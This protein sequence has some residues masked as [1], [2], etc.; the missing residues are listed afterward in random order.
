MRMPFPPLAFALAVLLLGCQSAPPPIELTDALIYTPS[1]TVAARLRGDFLAADGLAERMERLIELEGQALDLA[2]YEPLKLGALGHAILDLNYASLSGHYVLGRFYDHVGAAET[3]N[4]HGAWEQAVKEAMRVDAS[5][6]ADSPYA[7]ITP[8]EAQFYLRSE[9]LAPVGA[10]YRSSKATPFMLLVLGRPQETAPLRRLH[11]ALDGLHQVAIDRL[12]TDALG[13]EFSP[14]RLTGF[15]ARQGD[16]AAQTALGI[17]LA[18]QQR[19]DDALDWLQAGTR[20]D[21]VIAHNALARIHAAKSFQAETPEE[22]EAALENVLENSLRAISLG[23]SEAMYR[24]AAM[25]LEGVFGEDNAT[26]AIPLLRQAGELD[27]SDALL[28]LAYLHYAGERVPR[29][30]AKARDYFVRSAALKNS[31]ARLGYARYLMQEGTEGEGAGRAVGWLEEVVRET[32]DPEAMLMLGNLHARGV[33]ARQNFRAARRWYRQAAAAA[34]DQANIVN[35]VAWTLTVSDLERLRRVRFANRIMT[36]MMRSDEEAK[37][38]P[39]YLD[40]WAATYAAN[41]NFSEAVRLQEL[42][43]QEAINADRQDVLDILQEHLDLFLAGK[44][45]IERVP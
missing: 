36:K 26:S 3:E 7:A 27:N 20:L 23:S 14:L 4:H 9:G 17:L 24:L 28:Y 12:Q 15:L 16:P 30:P 21:N 43:L 45:V 18:G 10:L 44:P 40:T 2:K 5:G 31:A 33:G 22:R 19:T 42:A 25:Y 1:A 13:E 38:K 35:E 32:A 39:E 34:P 37:S 8:M 29:D 41:G 6:E 11:F